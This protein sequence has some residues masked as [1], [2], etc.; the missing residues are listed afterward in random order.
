MK[1][2]S[3][4][5]SLGIGRRYLEFFVENIDSRYVISL[6]GRRSSKS[7]SNMIWLKFLLSGKPKKLIMVAATFPALQLVM[8]DWQKATGLTVTGSLLY[9]YSCQMSNGSVVQFRNW[10]EAQKVQG[11]EAD[12]AYLEEWLNIKEEVIRVLGMSIREQIYMSANPTRKTRLL[13]DYLL[14]DGSNLLKTTY[15]D[16]P[17]LPEEQVREFEEIKKRSLMPNATLYDIYMAKVYCD[18]EF[19]DL[20]GRAFEKLEYN[21]YE[22]YLDVPSQEIDVMDLAFG[23][24]DR[25]ALCG[26]KLY[27]NKLYVHTYMYKQGTINAKELA[28]DLIEC[29]FNAYTPIQADYGGVGRQILDSLIL[30]QQNGEEWTE[31][32]LRMGFQ[33]NNVVKGKVLESIMALMALDAIV[34]DDSN[35][36]TRE[37]FEDAQLDENQKLK[38]DNDHAIACAR[39]AI[40]HFHAVGK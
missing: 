22:D 2:K 29:G 20:V 36:F 21:T 3:G 13:N 28:W 30:A 1:S 14:P 35:Q 16:N 18:G 40:N 27:N 9:G 26:F 12:Y 10:D 17:Y 19:A 6:G 24:S 33:I 25:T 39:Y 32:E 31:A 11:S 4:S 8:N 23:G 38:N 37:E 7:W 5:T 34:I 15:R